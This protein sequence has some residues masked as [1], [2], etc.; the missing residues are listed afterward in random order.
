MTSQ[1]RRRPRVV[2]DNNVIIPIL[3]Y[4]HPRTNWLVQLWQSGAIKPLIS[5][6][7]MAEFRAQVMERSPTPKP[8]QSQRFV[9]KSLRYYI[10]WCDHLALQDNTNTPRCRDPKDQMFID[11]AV[12]GQADF[13]ITKDDDLLSMNAETAFEILEDFR[14]HNS[15]NF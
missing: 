2:I 13:L 6:E 11:L 12:A 8:L 9:T 3:T 7:T 5:D 14:F 1:P 15:L 4:E 10:P